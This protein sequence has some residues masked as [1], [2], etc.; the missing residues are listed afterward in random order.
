MVWTDQPETA[1][2]TLRTWRGNE[3][4]SLMMIMFALG[5]CGCES[6]ER[7]LAFVFLLK[8]HVPSRTPDVARR[9]ELV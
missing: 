5:G 8:R 4:N 2:H 9:A 3:H 7:L 6:W 1:L